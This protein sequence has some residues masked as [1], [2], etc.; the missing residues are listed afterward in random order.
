MKIQD[1]FFRLFRLVL[2]L[3]Q[4]N[5]LQPPLQRHVPVRPDRL[6]RGHPLLQQLHVQPDL[7]HLLRSLHVSPIARG[8]VYHLTVQG[9][10]LL[11]GCGGDG[12]RHPPAQGGNTSHSINLDDNGLQRSRDVTTIFVAFLCQIILAIWVNTAPHLTSL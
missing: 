5:P 10:Q 1:L 2:I 11:L 3:Y 9:L 6:P 8:G 4:V 7:H 12:Q